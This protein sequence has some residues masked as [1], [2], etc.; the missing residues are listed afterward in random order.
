MATA[1][2]TPTPTPGPDVSTSLPP[3]VAQFHADVLARMDSAVGLA[4][5]V[6]ILVVAFLAIMTVKAMR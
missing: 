1:T 5:F 6:A 4:V 2:P 3:E